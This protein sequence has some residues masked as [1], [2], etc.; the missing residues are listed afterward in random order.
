MITDWIYKWIHTIK[1][2]DIYFYTDSDTNYCQINMAD[3]DTHPIS[4]SY[5]PLEY[6]NTDMIWILNTWYRYGLYRLVS[7]P[8]WSDSRTKVPIPISSLPSDHWAF[9]QLGELDDRVH[10]ET[11]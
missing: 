5:I 7:E 3:I 9:G 2:A 6:L 10:Q 11:I 1:N 4:T 8:F